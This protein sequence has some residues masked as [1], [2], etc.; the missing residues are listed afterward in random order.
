MHSI[1]RP[2]T[3]HPAGRGKRA[4]RGLLVG[5]GGGETMHKCIVCRKLI[6][7]PESVRKDLI[8]GM[9]MA[10]TRRLE[11]QEGRNRWNFNRFSA[12]DLRNGTN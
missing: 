2:S 3:R 10:A 6:R 1:S 7:L 11:Q 12:V 9:L 4:K 5:G 8:P